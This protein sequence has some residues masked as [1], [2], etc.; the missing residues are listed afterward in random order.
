MCALKIAILLLLNDPYF[1][2]SPNEVKVTKIQSVI[3]FSHSFKKS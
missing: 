2:I 3:N 1:R